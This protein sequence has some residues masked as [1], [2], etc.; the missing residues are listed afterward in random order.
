M[1][2]DAG[3]ITA[4]L[5]VADR[6]ATFEAVAERFATTIRGLVGIDAPYSGRADVDVAGLDLG[7]LPVPTDTPLSGQLRA[8]IHAEGSAAR[9][10]DAT[11]AAVIEALDARWNDQPVTLRSPATPALE[12][13]TVTIDALQ[14]DALDSTVAISGH[15]PLDAGATAGAL[16]VDAR[17]HLATLAGYAPR[18]TD[19]SADGTVTVHG[20]VR[21][22]AAAVDPDLTLALDNGLLIAPALGVPLAN[23]QLQARIAG[24]AAV[25]DRLSAEWG[26]AQ[27]AASGRTPLAFF[28]ALPVAVPPADGGA[29]VEARLSGFNPAALPGSPAD[30][31]GRVDLQLTGHAA[32]ANLAAAADRL[33]PARRCRS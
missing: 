19:L 31:S 29:T 20:S 8:R 33:P 3:D 2:C 5:A 32:S 30:V 24:G 10:A 12:N 15:V 14:I 16:E 23:V 1:G 22:T 9:A 21:G 18:G 27:L 11:V 4:T 28:G 7:A 6:S 26:S 13:R 17:L 25:I